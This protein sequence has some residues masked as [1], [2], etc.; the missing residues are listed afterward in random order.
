MAAL[1]AVALGWVGVQPVSAA[2][3]LLV[4]SVSTDSVLRYN[5]VT[6]SFVDAFV[7]TGSGGLF[8]PMDLV[9]GPDHNLYLSSVAS[10]SVLRYDGQTE[11]FLNVFVT[12]GGPLGA[13]WGLEFGPDCD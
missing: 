12:P 13:P 6:G 2:P 10:R 9:F 8:L 5:G 3:F 7:P 1:I 4:S 11:A